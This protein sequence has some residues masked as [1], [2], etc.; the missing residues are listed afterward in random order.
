MIYIFNHLLYF[1]FYSFVGWIGETIYCS[2][3]EK[4]FIKRGF[5][6]GPLCPIYGSAGV[7]LSMA[8]MPIYKH[9]ESNLWVGI[10]LTALCSMIIADIIEYLT[11]YIMEKLFNA[12]WWDYTDYPF[13]LNGRICLR[14]TIY[15][16]I[17]GAL[18]IYV[19]HPWTIIAFDEL[20]PD[21]NTRN[22]IVYVLLAI[23][24][25]DLIHAVISASDVRGFM[26]K[27][28]AVSDKLTNTADELKSFAENKSSNAKDF[29]QD[30]GTEFAVWFADISRQV[31]ELKNKYTEKAKTLRSRTA[32]RQYKNLVNVR[33]KTDKELS[34]L[35]KLL[36]KIS[37]Y[38]N[39][40]EW[41]E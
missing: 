33:L 8:L 35:E 10:A 18:F 25:I 29:F 20:L 15:W 32:K 1:F 30:K 34:Y 21:Q 2:I 16:A 14:H 39:T 5:L 13:N 40:D 12:R 27:F 19:L 3:G 9:F 7:V 37:E 17:A 24:V 38:H 22:I 23:F 31:S 26:S 11:S 36:N 4:K 41:K 6:T 28:S